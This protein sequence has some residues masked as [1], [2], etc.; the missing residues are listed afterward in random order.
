MKWSTGIVAGGIGLALAAGTAVAQP[1]VVIN[2][3]FINSPGTDQGREFL[4]LKSSAPSQS[5]SGLWFLVIEGD[6]EATGTVGTVDVAIPLEG[7]STGANGL[8]LIRDAATEFDPAPEAETTV[9]V[10][11]FV[12]DLENGG[13]TFIIVRGFTGAI[14]DDLDLDNNGVMESFPWSAVLDVIGYD[15]GEQLETDVNYAEQLGGLDVSAGDPDP[16]IAFT[17]DAIVRVCD[18]IYALDVFGSFP[19][20]FFA[21][22]LQTRGFPVNDPLPFDFELTPGR[23]NPGEC[24]PPPCPADFN[25]DGFLDFFDYDDY[26]GCFE[27]GSCPAGRTADF[28]GDDFVD[29]FDYDDFVSAFESGC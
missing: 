10:R 24:G 3:I 29:F 26:V 18:N 7:Y 22:E 9:L 12:P 19:G 25:G 8:F 23:A 28:N 6:G 17:A 11:D 5:L 14:G 2:E 21:D 4:E 15:E 1:L 13:S 20:P 27:T 16:N